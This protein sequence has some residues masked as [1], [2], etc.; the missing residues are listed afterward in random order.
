MRK[1]IEDHF[2]TEDL[3]LDGLAEMIQAYEKISQHRFSD[4]EAFR[5]AARCF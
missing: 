3:E 2:D 1:K 5:E 4:L